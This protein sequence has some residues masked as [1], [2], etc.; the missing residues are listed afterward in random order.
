MISAVM[1]YPHSEKIVMMGMSCAGKTTFAKL[2]EHEYVCFDQHFPWHD[3]ETLGLS[4]TAALEAIRQYCN[5]CSDFVLDGWH[6]G[7]R[8]CQMM[9]EACIYVVYAPYERIIAQYR[10]PVDHPEQHRHM[11]QKWYSIKYP[12]PCRYWLNDGYFIE[13][14]EEDFRAIIS[15]ERSQ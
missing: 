13:Q 2:L 6:L 9:P 15:S 3:I 14:T 8:D 11:Y 4:T 12:S 7:D 10:V 5:S 1:N